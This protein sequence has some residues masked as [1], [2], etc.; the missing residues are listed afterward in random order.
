MKI[1]RE[2]SRFGPVWKAKL[3]DLRKPREPN[4]LSRVSILGYDAW[5]NRVLGGI[6]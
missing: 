2:V 4:P 1:V 5:T 3:R 6:A